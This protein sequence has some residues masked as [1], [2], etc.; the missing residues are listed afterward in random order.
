MPLGHS[1]QGI[2]PIPQAELL[3]S[4]SSPDHRLLGGQYT[5]QMDRLKYSKGSG[6]SR[7]TDQNLAFLT[8]SQAVP[9][10]GLPRGR[11]AELG[12]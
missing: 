12:V 7:L 8:P 3:C 11:R 5:L 1:D 4:P 10:G 6:L 9:H 2:L